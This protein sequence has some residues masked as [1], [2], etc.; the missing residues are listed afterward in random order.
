VIFATLTDAKSM[1]DAV[2]GLGVDGRLMVIG[3][4]MQAIEVPPIAL[5]ST[6]RSISG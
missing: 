3:A 5:I 4:S 6:G 1:S 2:G